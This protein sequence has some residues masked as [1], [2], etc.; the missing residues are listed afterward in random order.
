MT[1]WFYG[2]AIPATGSTRGP[3][4]AGG[5]Y[6]ELPKARDRTLTLVVDPTTS[7]QAGFTIDGRAPEAALVDELATD[8]V[9]QRD[10]RVLFRGRIAP[11]SDTLDGTRHDTTFTAWSYR[12]L[13]RRRSMVNASTLTYTGTDQSTIAWALMDYTQALP[14]GNL[15]ISRGDGVTTGSARTV[16]FNKTDYLFDL[17]AN[18]AQMDQG[19]DWNIAPLHSATDLRMNMY[20]P[21]LLVNRG[22]VIEWGGE[23]C[24]SATRTFDPGTYANMAYL[25]GD[26]S[27]SL[28]PVL[29]T[30]AMI[31]TLPQGRWET[32]LGTT[33][34]VQ[35]SLIS[36]GAYTL[37]DMDKILASWQVTMRKGSWGGPDHIWAGDEVR[38][39]VRSGR[40][41]IDAD[42]R[43]VQMDITPGNSN[44]EVVVLTLGR[45]P[46]R[47]PREVVRL[48]RHVARLAKK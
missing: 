48:K 27:G 17:I 28:T 31:G 36:R 16:V 3:V 33:E 32:T 2:L 18:L 24:Q 20:A 7:D 37:S 10:N 25:T 44:D 41:D 38:W 22:V 13:L 14:G 11:D 40:I 47:I 30:E 5:V 15:G 9:I 23:L 45:L 46:V 6:A 34:L 29:V 35:S 39:R 26:S 19:F 12:E 4:P 1:R 42:Y 8:L 21:S 43:V